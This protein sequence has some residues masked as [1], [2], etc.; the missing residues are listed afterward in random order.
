MKRQLLGSFGIALTQ[1]AVLVVFTLVAAPALGQAT[2]TTAWGHPNLEGIWLDVYDTP[3]ER[4]P[5]L[6]DREFATAEER[7]ARD[8]ARRFDPGRN[9]RGPRG[10]PQDVSGAYNGVYTSVKPAGPRTSLVVDPPNGRIPALTPEAQREADIKREWRVM[11]MRNTPTCEQQAPGCEGGEYGPVSPRRFDV[12]PFYNTLRMNRHDGPEDQSLGDRCMLGATPDLNGHRR[13]VQGED[14]VAIAYD[15]GQGQGYQ[16]IVNLSGAHP[17][18]GV[19][20]R[21]GDSRGRWEGGT[22][23]IE[24]AN[25]SP[26][27]PFRASSVN[28]RLV[29]RYT[30]VDADTLTYEVTIEDPTVWTAPWTVRQE[31]KRQSDQQNRIYYEPRCHEG[32]YGLAAMFIGHRILEQEFAAGRAPDPFS[33]DTTTG[34]GGAR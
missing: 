26:K 9:R 28:R 24:T 7:A 8:D 22:L 27:F 20:L 15:T 12:P 19:R 18:S 29:E 17:P 33:L 21:H 11:L 14:A 4:A 34:G 32:N 5:E 23:V 10:S 13:I 16:R 25:F 1:A 30:V 3:L 6:G 2:G 31:L